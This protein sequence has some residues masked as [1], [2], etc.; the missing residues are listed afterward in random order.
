MVASAIVIGLESTSDPITKEQMGISTP[1]SQPTTDLAIQP[2]GGSSNR[3]FSPNARMAVDKA[4]T[5][6]PHPRI[7]R[8]P[9]PDFAASQAE[10]VFA[11]GILLHDVDC[12]DPWAVLFL[13]LE[14][15][16][17]LPPLSGLALRL[18]GAR[19]LHHSIHSAGA[20]E[21]YKSLDGARTCLETCHTGL[22]RSA[23]GM[24]AA[25]C[26]SERVAQEMIPQHSRSRDTHGFD[27]ICEAHIRCG[28]ILVLRTNA[29]HKAR[30]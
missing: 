23:I 7:H 22:H 12:L 30:V 10:A 19:A 5:V 11:S 4:G 2:Y 29:L 28:C 8:S 26:S 25:V 9:N 14:E 6:D 24:H 27:R 15:R 17:M 20:N 1:A 21:R 3:S 13:A 18:P 16:Q